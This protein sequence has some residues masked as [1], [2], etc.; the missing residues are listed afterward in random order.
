VCAAD[1]GRAAVCVAIECG[2]DA[3]VCTAATLECVWQMT[4]GRLCALRLSAAATLACVRQM[5]AGR[6]CVCCDQVRSQ[7]SHVRGRWR[8]VGGVRC[9]RV[10][11]AA[12]M[13]C[14]VADGVGAAVCPD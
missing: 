8:K 13:A 9:D 4:V 14:A 11:A 7:R 10:S 5:A 3:R 1:G 6:R 2:H 12:M